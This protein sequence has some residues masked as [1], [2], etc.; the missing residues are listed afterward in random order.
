MDTV[1]IY[2]KF[3]KSTEHNVRDLGGK[4]ICPL[5]L[6]TT[7]K[8][9]KDTGHVIKHCSK[10]KGKYDKNHISKK[11]LNSTRINDRDECNEDR[12][13]KNEMYDI[14]GKFWPLL[15]EGC[16]DDNRV[17]RR[18]RHGNDAAEIRKDFRSFLYDKYKVNWLYKSEHSIYDCSYLEHLRDQEIENDRER[19]MYKRRRIM[20]QSSRNIDDYLNHPSGNYSNGL[21]MNNLPFNSPRSGYAS[22]SSFNSPRSLQYTND[23]ITPFFDQ[24]EDFQFDDLLGDRRDNQ[25]PQESRMNNYTMNKRKNNIFLYTK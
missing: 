4:T 18:I 8:F 11:R 23:H 13:I 12:N 20:N 10:L 16:R 1:N 2:C 5:L 3:C 9:C 15:V 22:E 19:E 17:A 25:L 24:K 6:E 7:C 14:Y 21:P